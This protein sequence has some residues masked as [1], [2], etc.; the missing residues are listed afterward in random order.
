MSSS[1]TPTTTTTQRRF[2]GQVRPR[3]PTAEVE[4]PPQ[5]RRRRRTTTETTQRSKARKQPMTQP[6]RTLVLQYYD[7]LQRLTVATQTINMPAPLGFFLQQFIDQIIYYDDGF[8]FTRDTTK[9]AY[10][11]IREALRLKSYVPLDVVSVVQASKWSWILVESILDKDSQ[12]R[13]LLQ[14]LL[15]AF[16]IQAIASMI[17]IM[18][19][20]QTQLAERIAATQLQA[21]L[22]S[23]TTTTMPLQPLRSEQE[24]SLQTSI[25][26]Q[27]KYEQLVTQWTQLIYQSHYAY[28]QIVI[29][30]Q[31]WIEQLHLYTQSTFY[32]QTLPVPTALPPVLILNKISIGYVI[33]SDTIAQLLRT[34]RSSIIPLEVIDALIYGVDTGLD[35]SVQPILSENVTHALRIARA[36]LVRYRETSIMNNPQLQTTWIE[37]LDRYIDNLSNRLQHPNNSVAIFVIAYM[38]RQRGLLFAEDLEHTSRAYHNLM[39]NILQQMQ[40]IL[41]TV[42][43]YY[44]SVVMNASRGES[45]PPP[46]VF[47]T[48]GGTVLPTPAIIP[49]PTQVAATIPAIQPI[50]PFVFL[51]TSPVSPTQAGQQHMAIQPTSPSTLSFAT[52]ISPPGTTPTI[53]FMTEENEGFLPGEMVGI[54][55]SPTTSLS[56]FFV[57]SSL[58]PRE[59]LFFDME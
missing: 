23:S 24:E 21:S 10:D 4:E 8:M 57:S 16:V 43:A 7:M 5:R 30:I 51:E 37:E 55:L 33:L 6:I 27:Q 32:Q 20:Q 1:F 53:P 36:T 13:T 22:L 54:P 46:L 47:P 9:P 48:N 28:Q 59:S 18:Q 11:Q 17:T 40:N 26:A 41:S 38:I 34:T 50:S 25:A 42:R 14:Q 29:P 56:P 12:Q 49:T 15:L 2:A 44:T 19:E 52:T 58:S 3:S 35:P 45:L 31:F 39:W